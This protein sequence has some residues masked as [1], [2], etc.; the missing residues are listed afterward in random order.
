[1]WF[2]L[3][4]LFAAVPLLAWAA[5]ARTR[6]AGPAV[7]IALL[8]CA[9]LLVAVQ[10]GRVYAPVADVHVLYVPVTALL[11]A[12]GV[13][14]ERHQEGRGRGE[15][16]HHRKW[17]TRLLAAQFALTLCGSLLYLV[18]LEG[19]MPPDRAVPRLPAG[20]TVVSEFRS[21]GS[22]SCYRQ[23]E[24]GST[25]GLTDREILRAL[26]PPHELCRA[27]GWLIDRRSLCVGARVE[28]GRVRLSVSLAEVLD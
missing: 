14:V 19:S 18:T 16:V 21:C 3:G 6:Q 10:H 1:M 13:A 26:D 24:I 23:L 11:I 25:T 20:L 8:A 17:V 5:V 28:N 12:F 15:W 27:N 4:L 2:V 7:G 9:G 22:G